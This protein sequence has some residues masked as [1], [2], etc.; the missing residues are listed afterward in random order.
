MNIHFEYRTGRVCD[1]YYKHLTDKI[2]SLVGTIIS[3]IISVCSALAVGCSFIGSNNKGRV[4]L[5]GCQI[6][7][8]GLLM[9]WNK[10]L[11]HRLRLLIEDGII[12]RSYHQRIAALLPGIEWKVV[13]PGNQCIGL[14][15][16]SEYFLVYF[17]VK[18]DR[19]YRLLVFK[20]CFA[21]CY[22]SQAVIRLNRLVPLSLYNPGVFSLIEPSDQF[23]WE[24]SLPDNL[25][26]YTA[27]IITMS[28]KYTIDDILADLS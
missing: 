22:E 28:R 18:S 3:G 20:K 17:Y 5:F 8:F 16:D 25:S 27:H 14:S 6:L 11:K 1:V 13:E 24:D 15:R 12:R 4:L 2:N 9:W 19:R 23:L 7:L 26:A 21:D 10:S